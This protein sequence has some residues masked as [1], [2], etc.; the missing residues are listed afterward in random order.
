MATLNPE[1]EPYRHG[2]LAVGD[3]QSIYWET[4]G[5]PAG[6]PA[7]VLHGGPGSGCSTTLRRLFNPDA[8]CVVL[9]DQRGCGRSRPNAGDIR[10]DLACNTTAHLISDIERLRAHLNIERW[11]VFGGSWG[12]TLALAYAQSHPSTVTEIVLAGVTTTRG[13]EIDWL[14]GH[15][16][17]LLPRQW[18]EFRSGAP[19]GGFG[20]DLVDAYARRLLH[21]DAD[22]RA[23]AA[24]DWCKWEAALVDVDSRTKT[25][26][27]WSDP[28]FRLTFA[29]IVTHYFRHGAWLEDGALLNNAGAL[30]GI[31]GVMVHSRLDLAAPLAT[32]WEL[33]QVWQDAQLVTVDGAVHA[34]TGPGMAEEVVAATDRFAGVR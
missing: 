4:C 25:S 18:A 23:K 6:K 16:G 20:R 14:Y 10:I 17:Q 5:N 32:A 33:S 31:R 26:D 22:V 1:I 11:L 30:A 3:G 24:W 28:A 8:Y 15:V 2:W 9:F 21:A 7:L 12:S 19:E 29:R 27:R 34:A 13:S